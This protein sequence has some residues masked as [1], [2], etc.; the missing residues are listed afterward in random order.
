MGQNA[1]NTGQGISSAQTNM[2]KIALQ[3]GQNQAGMWQDIGSAP[4]NA[5]AGNYYG[6]KAGLW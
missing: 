5:L 4:V 1:L 3:Q 6:Q 2:S